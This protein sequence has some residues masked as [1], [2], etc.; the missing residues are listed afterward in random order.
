MSSLQGSS[1]IYGEGL[2]L[3]RGKGLSIGSLGERDSEGQE[4]SDVVFRNVSLLRSVHGVRI[5][6]WK[7]PESGLEGAK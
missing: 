7:A 2:Q 3:R 4:V 1:K 6:T 5:K